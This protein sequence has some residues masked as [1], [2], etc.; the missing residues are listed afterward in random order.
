MK[1]KQ[2]AIADLQADEDLQSRTSCKVHLTQADKVCMYPSCFVMY[3][4]VT[5]WQQVYCPLD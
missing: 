1:S 3:Y 4:R 2:L 5:P